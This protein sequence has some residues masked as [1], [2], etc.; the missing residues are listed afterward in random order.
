MPPLGMQ[1]GSR[2]GEEW[3]EEGGELYPAIT[4]QCPRVADHH[5]VSLVIPGSEVQSQPLVRALRVKGMTY[6][7]LAG[8]ITIMEEDLKIHGGALSQARA[9]FNAT[10]YL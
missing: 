6:D 9:T 8:K 3:E 2:D 1:I 10:R 4:H 5:P 7:D